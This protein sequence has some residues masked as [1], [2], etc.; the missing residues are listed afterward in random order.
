M[1]IA[2][3]LH[4]TTI[5]HKSAFGQS[6][7]VRV[8]QVIEGEGSVRDYEQYVPIGNAVKKLHVWKNQG[9][10][11]AYV[12]SHET[13]GDVEKDKSVLRKY[14]FP[15]GEVLFRKD[16]ENYKDVIESLM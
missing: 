10:E 13:R 6:R 9:V 14:T 8:K 12:S 11:M 3:F 7:E 16:G 4:G 5:M 15:E 1:K 2:I